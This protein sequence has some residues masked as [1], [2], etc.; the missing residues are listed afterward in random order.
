MFDTRGLHRDVGR[1]VADAEHEHVPVDEALVGLAV[2]VGV[3]LIAG[4]ALLAGEGRR[5]KLR[6]PMVPVGDHDRV[7]GEST[8]VVERHS[9]AAVALGGDERDIRAKADPIAKA[10]VVDVVVEVTGDLAVVGVVR[11]VL[12]HRIARLLHHLAGGVDEQRAVGGRQPV[13]VLVAPVAAD[14]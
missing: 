8:A 13:V 12:R 11:K 6:I 3:E 5:G 2:E 4:E 1:R 10:E 14:A 9:P 7:I